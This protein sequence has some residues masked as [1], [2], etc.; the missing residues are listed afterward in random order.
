MDALRDNSALLVIF[1]IT[2]IIQLQV[3][4]TKVWN[5]VKQKKSLQISHLKE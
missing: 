1:T 2:N 5:N 3:F 4:P